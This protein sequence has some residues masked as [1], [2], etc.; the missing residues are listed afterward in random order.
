[1]MSGRSS[2]CR[3]N[4]AHR[5]GVAGDLLTSHGFKVAGAIGAQNYEAEGGTLTK[6]VLPVPAAAEKP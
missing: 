6:I 5:A 4:H 1:M 3:P 2:N